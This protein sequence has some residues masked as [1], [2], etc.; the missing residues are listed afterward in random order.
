VTIAERGL[1]AAQARV[2]SLRK[3]R[4]ALDTQVSTTDSE[5][6]SAKYYRDKA[7]AAVMRD[8][9][10]AFIKQALKEAGDL[11]EQLSAKRAELNFL[12]GACFDSVSDR[13][14]AKPISDFM[15]APAYPWEFGMRTSVHPALEPW[16]QAR[17]ALATDPDSPLPV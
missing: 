6:E 8:E 1:S 10:G 12:K 5:I 11:Q 3:T 2:A 9:A 4:D 15:A 7:I 14:A 17:E 13:E 16:H